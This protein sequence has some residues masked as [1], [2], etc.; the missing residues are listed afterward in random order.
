MRERHSQQVFYWL[1]SCL[2]QHSPSLNKFLKNYSSTHSQTD[3]TEACIHWAGTAFSC[4]GCASSLSL[5]L[6]LSRPAEKPRMNNILTSQT[7]PYEMSF[8]RSFQNLTH[9]PPSYEMA[10]KVDLSTYSSLHYCPSYMRDW[11]IHF[12]TFMCRIHMIN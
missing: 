1:S 12:H 6:S 10:M 4:M 3:A 5:S 7:E 8:S 11:E 2:D 9:L